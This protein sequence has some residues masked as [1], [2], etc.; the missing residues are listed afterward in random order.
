[1]EHLMNINEIKTKKASVFA[2]NNVVYFKGDFDLL[3]NQNF[4]DPFFKEVIKQ[5]S[6]K[7]TFDLS[8][9][10]FMNSRVI[11]SFVS[12]F[13]NRKSGSKVILKVNKLTPWQKTSVKILAKLDPNKIIIEEEV[14]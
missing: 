10:T 3:D 13:L 12:F 7:I 2:K 5:M 9:T 8:E 14:K 4:L 1:M 11:N 6:D